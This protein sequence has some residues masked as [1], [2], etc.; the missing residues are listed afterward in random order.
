MWVVS[1]S[2]RAD[3]EL[4]KKYEY[5]LSNGKFYELAL[6][7]KVFGGIQ[8]GSQEELVNFYQNARLSSKRRVFTAWKVVHQSEKR[9][10]KDI[11]DLHLIDHTFQA[12]KQYR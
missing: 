12:L 2:F 3:E 4:L 1:S 9:L 7:F 11:H 10:V 5:F 8:P 6:L